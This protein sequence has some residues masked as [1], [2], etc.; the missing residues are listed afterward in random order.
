MPNYITVDVENTT[1]K[2]NDKYSDYTP[3]NP[4]NRLVSI[5]WKVNDGPVQ[6]FFVYHNELINWADK[7]GRIDHVIE[8]RE[9]LAKADVLIAHNV[10]YEL[11]WLTESGF[12]V[13]H[14]DVEDTMI[15]EYIMARGRSDIGFNLAD[16]CKRYKVTEKGD[17]FQRYPNLQISEMPIGEV[18]DYGKTDVQACYELWNAQQD[19]LN[20]D[21]YLCLHET[22]RMSNEF[23]RV[24]ADMERNGVAIDEAA[25]EEVK[26]TFTIEAE[27]LKRDLTILVHKV[28]GDTPVNLDSPKQL[29][30]VIY[31]RKIKEG[32]EEEWL[33]TF[34]VGKDERGKNLR[35]PRMSYQ[36][37]AGCITSLTETVLKTEVERC[38]DCQ[39][40]GFTP[41]FKKDGSAFKRNPKCKTC[42]GDG[43]IFK[44]IN[45]IAG[46]KMKPNNI[47]FTTV[48]G[49]STGHTFLEELL[50]QAQEKGKNDA[51]E[52][53]GKLQR[54]SSVS[55]YLSNFV[56][57]ITTFKQG[58]LLHPNF[59]QCLTA[60]GRL[61]SSKPNLQNQPRETTFP[62]RRVFRSSFEGGSIIEADF[63]TLEFTAAVHL[64]E[65]KRGRQDII[66]GLDI[67]TQTRD[68]ICASGEIIDRT[69]A[70]RHTFKP[71]YGG[72][73]GTEAQRKYYK[74]FLNELYRDIGDWH[75]RL[76]EEAIS[77][78]IITLPTGRQYIFPDVVRTW[79]GGSSRYTQIVNYPVQGFATADI[80]PCAIIRLWHEMR[81]RNL[82]SKLVLT[83]HDSVVADVPPDER[84]LMVELLSKIAEYA[85]EELMRRYEIK[86]FVPLACEVKAGPNLMDCKKV[87]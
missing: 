82:R 15:R 40:K 1:T 43:I 36:D 19:R 2:L 54:L 24:L 56:G 86:M 52:F 59:S 4:L 27:D 37:Y 83:V 10:K 44:E 73:S 87:A 9:A 69:K 45:E 58:D 71:L 79:K 11:A 16:S 7:E 23:C 8:F 66:D 14:L 32:K 5:G 84:G 34:N 60:T 68:V 85:E 61:S 31:S 72:K 28:M 13:S 20:K 30:E 41:K 63:K 75:G 81:S 3:Y 21:D 42:E 6:Y 25:L 49:F 64:A 47:N 12:D 53:L 17:I 35:R 26:Q 65:D 78:K 48:S 77:K 46:F 74:A 55:S 70:K 62:I 33:S 57:G 38:E 39:G 50:E 67:H 51:A 18:E 29:S 80:V 22:I 76:Q